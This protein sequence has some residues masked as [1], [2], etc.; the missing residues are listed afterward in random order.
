MHTAPFISL[1]SLQ[2]RAT[3]TLVDPKKVKA[4]QERAE[5]EAIKGRERL[6]D[7]QS[8]AMRKFSMPRSRMPQ[9]LN[10]G[11]WGR[12]EARRR[13]MHSTLMEGLRGANMLAVRVCMHACTL[14]GSMRLHAINAALPLLCPLCPPRPLCLPCRLP[15][16][17]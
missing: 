3:T 10:A 11:G 5:A 13:A 1:P 15:R 14:H 12:L 6:A 17:G 16:G 4:E 8:K 9:Q 7:K 2:V